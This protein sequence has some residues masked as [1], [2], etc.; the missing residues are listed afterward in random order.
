MVQP[1][2]YTMKT[3]SPG[4]VFF[5]SIQLGQQQQQV[6]AQRE[7]A[8][9]KSEEALRGKQLQSDIASWV[10]NPT[11]E[12]FREL[13]KKYPLEFTK[14]AGVQKAVG[15]IDRPAIRSVSA[16]ALMAHRNN[17]PEQVLS[18]LDQRIEASQDNP[19]LQKKLQDMKK[20]YQLYPDNKKLQEA[21]IVTVLAQDDEGIK[22]YD[23][24]FKQTEPFVT[25]GDKIYLRSEIDRAVAAAEKTGD[26]NIR[27]KPVIPMEAANDLKSGLVTKEAFDKA[28]GPGSA[29]KILGTGGQTATPSGN[30]QGQ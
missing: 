14:L 29:A 12:G 23:R 17:Q 8:R 28:F 13:N 30:F 4:E 19:T 7:E 27:V 26:P 18:I 2:D 3:P 11:P 24:A 6:A 1:Y 20:G 16:D 10:D 25:A 9:L 22:I 15:D 5:K 21:A